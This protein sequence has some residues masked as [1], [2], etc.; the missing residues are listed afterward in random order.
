LNARQNIDAALVAR[1]LASQFPQWGG[2]AI[3]PVEPGGWDNRMFRLGDRMVVR[4]PSAAEYAQQ[5]DKEHHW[6]PRLA[7]CLPLAIPVPLAMGKPAEDYPWNWSVYEWLPGSPV[8]SDTATDLVA[9]AKKLAEFLLALQRIEARGGPPPGPHNFWRGGPLSIYDAEARE[10]IA[11]LDGQTDSAALRR[12][13]DAA[14]ESTWRS[15]PVW[16]H[17]DLS[18]DN[19]L[20]KGGALTAVVDFGCL[21]IGDPA[22]DL[23]IAWTLLDREARNAFRAAVFLDVETWMRGVGW[24]AWKAAIVLAQGQSAAPFEIARARRTIRELLVDQGNS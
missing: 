5:V 21:G 3:R 23:A 20:M 11:A 16:V 9:I 19:L 24:A 13:W 6:L 22:C 14:V 18:P 1:L 7:P 10:A 8:G 12:M 17:G 4:L 15:E 2:L